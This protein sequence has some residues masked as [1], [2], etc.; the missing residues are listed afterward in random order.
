M[1]DASAHPLVR[2]VCLGLATL[3]VLQYVDRAPGPDAKATSQEHA[4]AAGGPATNA[5]VTFAALG[6]DAL[7]VTAVGDDDAGHLVRTDL[8]THGVEVV[9]LTVDS[10]FRTP[11]SSITVS[12]ATGERSIVGS[13]AAGAPVL[14]ASD[15]QLESILDGAGVLLLDGH[16]PAVAVRAAQVAHRLGVPVVLDLGRWKP[17]FGDVVPLADH[18]VCSEGVRPP[19]WEDARHAESMARLQELG[20]GCVVATRGAR[21]A[22][23][24]AEGGASEEVPVPQVEAV[25]SLGAGD[26]FHGAYAF[27]IAVGV[28]GSDHSLEGVRRAVTRGIGVASLRVQHRGPR[29]WLAFLSHL[30]P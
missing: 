18:A 21:A 11:V 28:S 15:E 13:D 9:E 17:V 29:T 2:G 1:S 14:E 23:V 27:E 24:L 25:D 6:G 20:A 22:L 12:T 30:T 26:A 3:D 16:H 5:A 7:L 8:A 19:G 4:L 10:A